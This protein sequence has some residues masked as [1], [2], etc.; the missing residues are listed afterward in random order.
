MKKLDVVDVS[1]AVLY[2]VALDV[3]FVISVGPLYGGQPELQAF[4]PANPLKVLAGY[5]AAL[6]CFWLFRLARKRGAVSG[7]V[8][9]VQYIFIVV[10]YTTLYG[11]EDLPTTY[12]GLILLGY[13]TAVAFIALIPAVKLRPAGALIRYM[14]AGSAGLIMLYVFG[15]L[16]ATGGLH[17]LNFN[18]AD[19]YTVRQEYI[20]NLLPGLAYFVS[21]TGYVF[22]M[23]L[24]VIFLQQWKEGRWWALVGIGTTLLLQL[25]LFGMTN[26]KTFLFTPFAIMGLI[27]TTRRI[28][29]YRAVLIG[30]LAVICLLFIVDLV[31]PFGTALLK[32]AYF[33]PAAMHNLY[34]QY[35][36]KH[37]FASGSGGALGEWLGAPYNDYPL[38]L[39][40]DHYLGT[41]E[42]PNAGWMA[43]AYANFGAVGIF[44]YG[45]ILAFILRLADFL[46]KKIAEPG[47]TEGLMLTPAVVLCSSALG[48]ALLTHGLLVLLVTL[49]VLKATESTRWRVVYAA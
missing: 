1:M 40:A 26:F 48:T 35:F 22:N 18:L 43:D 39:V 11:F 12:I 36:S 6:T 28:S 13:G 33:D 23:V 5:V 14:F 9:F 31:T 24:L 10:P 27:W 44:L 19:V 15:G 2:K 41:A 8:I 17:R 45:V 37:P 16:I 46:A 3:S 20:E 49:W 47:V 32:R 38:Q 7:F 25:L 42:H 4:G 29:F 30:S 21:W 34:F